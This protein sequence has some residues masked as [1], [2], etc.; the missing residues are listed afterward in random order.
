[1]NSEKAAEAAAPPAAAAEAP[2]G[3][4]Q[5]VKLV[6]GRYYPLTWGNPNVGI[7][8]LAELVGLDRKYGFARKFIRAVVIERR[9]STYLVDVADLHVGSYYE[10]KCP[11]SW[12]HPDERYYYRIVNIDLAKG[13][14]VIENLEKKDVVFALREAEAGGDDAP[15]W[16]GGHAV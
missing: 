10:E 14:V 16:S 6:R 4:V 15:V 12:R 11:C 3:D 5:R 9:E 2:S 8:Y 7:P 13:E 1:L